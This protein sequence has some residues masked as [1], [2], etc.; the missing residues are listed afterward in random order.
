MLTLDHWLSSVVED[1]CLLLLF[2]LVKGRSMKC[3][4]QF[5]VES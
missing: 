3:N 4:S 5:K 2:N 1:L